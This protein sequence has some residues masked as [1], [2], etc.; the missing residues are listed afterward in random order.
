AI[1]T[2]LGRHNV[3]IANFA[4]GRQGD[5]AVGVVIVD[6]P[7]VADRVLDEIR[8]VKGV[9][10]VRLVRVLL[11]IRRRP[12]RWNYRNPTRSSDPSSILT[13]S[14]A[15]AAIFC[16]RYPTTSSPSFARTTP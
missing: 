4:L 6:T 12:A 5:S 7:T 16:T 1:G 3:N 9:R 10:E 14:T 8:G 11:K 2:I 13:S 15:S